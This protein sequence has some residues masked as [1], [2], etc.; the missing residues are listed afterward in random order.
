M[1][2]ASDVPV[3]F[4]ADIRPLFRPSDVRAMTFVFDLSTYEDVCDNA[5]AILERLRSGDMPCDEP[6]PADRV[7][8]FARWVEAGMPR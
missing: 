4:E 5:D 2:P 1:V 8:L 3:G 6:W 7:A